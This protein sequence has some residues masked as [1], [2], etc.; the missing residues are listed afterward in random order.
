MVRRFTKVV[1]IHLAFGGV[2]IV[3][4]FDLKS[5]FLKPKPGKA[6]SRKEFEG[7]RACRAD[8]RVR[9][10][11]IHVPTPNLVPEYCCIIP[12]T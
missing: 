1:A 8:S 12:H 7:L 10:I 3:R 6:Y 4:P 5:G 2:D 11:V 9:A